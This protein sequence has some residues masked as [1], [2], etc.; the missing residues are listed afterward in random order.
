[1]NDKFSVLEFIQ[2]TI[3]NCKTVDEVLI[4]D[5]SQNGY[6]YERLWDICIKFGQ[7]DLTR[8]KTDVKHYFGNVNTGV[9]AM[10]LNAN[11]FKTEFLNKP[12]ISGNSGGYS[13]ISFRITEDGI[14]KEYIS[15]CKFFENEKEIDKY[16]LQKLC[17]LLDIKSDPKIQKEY[18]ILLFVNDRKKFIKKA[19]SANSSSKKLITYISPNG[20]FENIYDKTDLERNYYELRKVLEIYNYLDDIDVFADKYLKS[21]NHQVF[22]PKFHQDLFVEKILQI[23]HREKDND[24]ILVGAVPRSGKTY[25]I[26]GTVLEYVKKNIDKQ[27]KF[28]IIT[29]APTETIQQYKDVF[30]DYIDFS[31]LDIETIDVK[32]MDELVKERKGHN[33]HKVYI[34]SKQRLGYPDKS[35]DDIKKMVFQK[36]K[37]HNILMFMDDSILLREYLKLGGLESDLEEE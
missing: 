29:P 32:N 4:K 14:E 24:K 15:S 33:K 17:T 34:V 21:K 35:D 5:R 28:V 11:V 25:I 1:M 7:F 10:K 13:D 2:K 3:K 36:I 20:N 27:C 9:E 31:N 19:N 12:V 22:Q 6:L 18:Q 16:D 8:G 23:L 30:R 26:A 37:E